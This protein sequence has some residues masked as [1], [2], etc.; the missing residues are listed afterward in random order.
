MHKIAILY[1]CTGKYDV[2]WKEFYISCEKYFLPNSE[3]KYFVFTDAEEIYAEDDN[4]RIYKIYQKKMGWPYDTLM[5][6][7]LFSHIENKLEEFEYIFFL[8][9][10][11]L[12][13][14]TVNESELLDTQ[15]ELFVVL[16]PGWINRNKFFL[17]YERNKKSTAYIPYGAG[18]K[19]FMGGVNGGTAE[20][21]L[22][23]I[24]TLKKNIQTDLDNHIIAKWHDESQLNRY[25]LDYENYKIL[26]PSFGYPE[27]WILPYE[28]IVL[29]RDKDKVFN[30]SD[31]KGYKAGWVYIKK[32]IRS[33]LNKLFHR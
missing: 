18:D 28:P 17:P 15:S 12:F 7:E 33:W 16:H 4:P 24:N 27:N 1:I 31:V 22:K 8:N 26:P 13:L 32:I 10:N 2:F 6:F 3:K 21:Y 19:Y 11:V 20:A 14:H 5:R 29:I 25:M 23:L 9:A 30:T